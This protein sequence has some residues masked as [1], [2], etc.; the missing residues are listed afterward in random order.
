MEGYPCVFCDSSD[1]PNAENGTQKV[2]KK[3]IDFDL[4]DNYVTLMVILTQ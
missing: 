4:L 1:I 2:L 3:D